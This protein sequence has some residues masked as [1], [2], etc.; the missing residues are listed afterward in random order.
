M[1]ALIQLV[2]INIFLILKNALFDVTSIANITKSAQKQIQFHEM[3]K[4]SWKTRKQC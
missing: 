3:V 4:V 1:P 2:F